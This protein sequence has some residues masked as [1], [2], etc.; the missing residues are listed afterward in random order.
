LAKRKKLDPNRFRKED[1]KG[2]FSF[3]P[4]RRSAFTWGLI[5]GGAGGLFMLQPEIV[6]QIVGVF[7]VVL[8]SNY[9]IN[10]AARRIPRWH[11]TV[12]SF[13]GV[14]LAM[15]GVIILGT[16]VLAYVRAGGTTG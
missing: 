7:A 4:I 6:W 11:A 2:L 5:A 14:M 15:F 3:D 8:I 9:H 16:I 10:K 12:I 13:L 1:D